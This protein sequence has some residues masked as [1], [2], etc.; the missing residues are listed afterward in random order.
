MDI[1]GKAH[2]LVMDGRKLLLFKKRRKGAEPDL[3]IVTP[4]L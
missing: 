2:M 4:S 1:H 3:N